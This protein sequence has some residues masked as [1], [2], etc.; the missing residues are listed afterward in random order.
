MLYFSTSPSTCHLVDSYFAT[1]YI[2]H[3]DLIFLKVAIWDYFFVDLHWRNPYVQF[4]NFLFFYFQLFL[5]LLCCLLL[6]QLMYLLNYCMIL[7]VNYSFYIFIC[8]FC[9]F[10]PKHNKK[11]HPSEIAFLYIWKITSDDSLDF[12][13]LFWNIFLSCKFYMPKVWQI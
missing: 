12:H 10:N 2:S 6:P 8:Y 9:S 7:V 5:H 4:V 11:S 1:T 13:K 3:Y